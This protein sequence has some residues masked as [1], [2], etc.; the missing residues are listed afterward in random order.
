MHDRPLESMLLKCSCV[1]GALWVI[2][3]YLPLHTNHRNKR[4][5]LDKH[6][7][8]ILSHNNK[9]GQSNYNIDIVD[10]YL[11]YEHQH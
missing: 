10:I 7:A 9:D 1:N 5:T 4:L 2:S 8:L 11:L 6:L 3:N